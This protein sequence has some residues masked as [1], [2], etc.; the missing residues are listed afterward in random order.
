M[1]MKNYLSSNFD[2]VKDFYSN[3]HN[4]DD[5]VVCITT[6]LYANKD[7]VVE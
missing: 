5:L 4:T 2:D 1:N 3:I 7:D 6:A